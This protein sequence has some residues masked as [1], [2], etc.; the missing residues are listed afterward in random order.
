VPVVPQQA[1]SAENEAAINELMSMGFPR[2]QCVAALRAAY[3]NVE[4]AVEYLLNGIPSNVRPPA[5]GGQGEG[6]GQPLGVEHLRALF[7]HP[8][9]A[10]IKQ[11]IRT[12]P[13]ALQPILAQISQSSPQIYS[14]SH[15]LHSLLLNIL[16]SS[17]E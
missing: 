5:A 12:N 9:F 2:E 6:D 1:V 8:Q 10:Q 14:V 4:R 16:N 7:N 13:Q 11:L 3:N 15:T 17:K